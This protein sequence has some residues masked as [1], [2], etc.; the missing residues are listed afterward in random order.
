MYKAFILANAHEISNNRVI[1]FAGRHSVVFSRAAIGFWL[2]LPLAVA[3][4]IVGGGQRREKML[5]LIFA[6]VYA[7]TIVPFFI[8][9]RFRMPLVAVLVI[10]AAAAV[11]ALAT[12][13]R[14]RS[15]DRKTV[16]AIAAAVVI[17]VV[18]RPLPA[19]QATDAQA[20]FN[21]AEAYRMH[22]DFDHA[23]RWYEQALI[24]FPAYCD[25]AYN[26][27]RI[28][29]EI[30]PDAYRVVEVLEPV[31]EPC[32]ADFELQQLLRRALRA[33]GRGGA[34]GGENPSEGGQGRPS[35]A[36]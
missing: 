31:A 26:L 19:L 22:G 33:V 10:F 21:E 7:A 18:I 25:A 15:F 11:S 16:T 3:G 35:N 17:A 24:E 13:F 29:T 30:A 34:I 5:L 14:G 23:A 12:S 6:G 2:V 4:M 20:F 9:A 8:N 1:E 27:A 32:A 36:P 28:H